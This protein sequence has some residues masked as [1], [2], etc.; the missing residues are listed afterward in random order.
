MYEHFTEILPDEFVELS[1]RNEARVTFRV[2]TRND[3]MALAP[4][5][6]SL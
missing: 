4:A 3:G 6:V 5:G 1:G 2:T